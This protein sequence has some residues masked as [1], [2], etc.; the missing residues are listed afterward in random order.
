MESKFIIMKPLPI[1]I[2][3]VQKELELERAALSSLIATDPFLLQHCVP[4]LFEKQP[5]PPKP[6]RQP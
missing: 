4:V 3:S 5:A 6:S 1:F 2:S